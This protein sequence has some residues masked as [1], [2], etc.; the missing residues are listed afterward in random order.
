M[1]AAGAGQLLNS[2]FLS[3]LILERRL[4]TDANAILFDNFEHFLFHILIIDKSLRQFIRLKLIVLNYLLVIFI[5]F[6][7]S[8]GYKVDGRRCHL[9]QNLLIHIVKLICIYL[10]VLFLIE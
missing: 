8:H 7:L 1:V 3:I 4:E 10:S 5:V 9:L 2:V 6:T